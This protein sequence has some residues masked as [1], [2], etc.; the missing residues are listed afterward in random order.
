MFTR[1]T[2]AGLIAGLVLGAGFVRPTPAA[3]DPGIEE[4]IE[5][6]SE[7]LARSP[8]DT[9]LLLFR[10]D[11][12]RRNEQW[13][14][15]LAD[16]SMIDVMG[17][18]PRTHLVRARIRLD[19]GDE[20]SALRWLESSAPSMPRMARAEAY[21]LM[22]EIHEEAGR[23]D[24]AIHAYDTSLASHDEVGVYLSRGRLLVFAGR[25]EEAISGYETGVQILAGPAILRAELVELLLALGEHTRALVHADAL[26]A[27]ARATS[28][29]R[30]MRARIYE[31][32]GEHERAL[33]EREAALA[34]AE[35]V[36]SRRNSAL[37]RLERARALL[38]LGRDA[39]ALD[40]LRRVVRRA[41]ILAEARSL[42]HRVETG[43]GR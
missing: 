14:E 24:E 23:V 10:A 41:P 33:A 39:E 6:L 37:A 22:A 5:E 20:A 32:Q 7:S 31:A 2:W 42:L 17:G 43:G 38:A 25:F 13:D 34:D 27:A 18:D 36:L 1:A 40:D 15:A 28:R 21:A 30:V 29:F 26:V 12:Y 8:R 4:E 35:R 16:L 3:A 11:L 19:Q 9:R